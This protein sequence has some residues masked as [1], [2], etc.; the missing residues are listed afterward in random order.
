MK[1]PILLTALTFSLSL[2]A[3][4]GS[5]NSPGADTVSSLS[6]GSSLSSLSSGGSTS[7]TPIESLDEPPAAVE[8]LESSTETTP[9][10]VAE[11][12][13]EAAAEAAPE[14][15]A[16]TAPETPV[17]TP[18][19]E[20]PVADMDSIPDMDINAPYVPA[21]SSLGGGRGYSV[22]GNFLIDQDT[23][24][25][26]QAVNLVSDGSNLYVA[27]VDVKMPAKGTVIQMDTSGGAWKDLG[28]SLIA[29]FTLGAAGYK[30]S[31]TIQ[32]IALD[33]SGNL[34]VADSQNQLFSMAAS[35]RQITTVKTALSNVLDATSVGNAVFVATTTGIQK[36]DA[37]L[38]ASSTF[39]QVIPSG[40]M[41]RDSQGNLYVVSNNTIQ[42]IDS[43]GQAS[44]VVSGLNAPL[45][46]SVD[47]AGNIFVL[48]SDGIKYYKSSGE[49]LGS[50]GAGDFVTP[51]SIFVDA[52]GTVYVADA[53]TSHK[54]SQ[55]VRFVKG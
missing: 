25:Q 33:D 5:V 8:S 27:A 32:G 15:P 50:F 12:T 29:T 44:Q 53:G 19:G 40:G 49:S 4:G 42:K 7:L 36:F 13:S 39:S 14:T 20:T 46:V 24:N 52:S 18:T 47:S 16:E 37:S 41:G 21:G 10:A 28:K 9:E 45:D 31:K 26:W 38:S 22:D 6:N 3:C 34:I 2:T 51:K 30:M 35:D 48:E 1:K 54:D 23:F 55:I 17:E 11:P 43:S